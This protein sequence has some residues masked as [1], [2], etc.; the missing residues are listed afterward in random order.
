MT[1]TWLLAEDRQV[2]YMLCCYTGLN[3]MKV[4]STK[5]LSIL[6]SQVHDCII[7]SDKQKTSCRVRDADLVIINWTRQCATTG[8]E[9]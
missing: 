6:I 1:P 9:K 2:Y 3:A 5:Q 7:G 8:D 4:D